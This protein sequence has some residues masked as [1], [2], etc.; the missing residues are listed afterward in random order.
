MTPRGG[1]DGEVLFAM[2]DTQSYSLQYGA[3]PKVLK[4]FG[5]EAQEAFISS[6]GPVSAAPLITPTVA[7]AEGTL[8]ISF[9]FLANSA[10]E[11]RS[12]IG[13]GQLSFA[14]GLDS[15]ISY[16]TS[17][18][19]WSVDSTRLPQCKPKQAPC[20]VCKPRAPCR[21]APAPAAK[22]N[23]VDAESGAALFASDPGLLLLVLTGLTVAALF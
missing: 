9:G 11:R 23:D 8:T 20:P 14:V 1:E 4:S 2:H 19:C 21:G 16:H 15:A 10:I 5:S 13:T 18:G 7:Y 12:V 17:R 3:L 22:E 6:L